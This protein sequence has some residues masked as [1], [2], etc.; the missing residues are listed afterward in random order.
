[1]NDD[2]DSRVS[3]IAQLIKNPPAMQETLFQFLGRED[4]LEKE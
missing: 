4:S 2:A 1:M 3:L